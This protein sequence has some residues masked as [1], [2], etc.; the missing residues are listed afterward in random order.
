RD[1]RHPDCHDD[2]GGE[3]DSH[4]RPVLPAAL[5]CFTASRSPDGSF[6]CR[7]DIYIK[8]CAGH[9]AYPAGENVGPKLHAGQ[10]VKVIAEIKRNHRT[11]PKQKNQLG[12]LLADS[13]VDRAKFF[14]PLRNH[15]DSFA[16][17]ESS[18]EIGQSSDE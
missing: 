6:A 5:H 2:C 1:L 13:A 11:E 4:K 17:D 7:A 15:C 16:G 8:E 10:A 3:T 18:D 14:V 9:Y 12:A